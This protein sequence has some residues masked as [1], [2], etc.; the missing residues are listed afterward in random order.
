ML[1]IN[2]R[3]FVT[4]RLADKTGTNFIPTKG[5]AVITIMNDEV[6]EYKFLKPLVDEYTGFIHS[7]GGII[8]SDIE[9]MIR[10]GKLSF[11]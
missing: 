6:A 4:K 8:L 5:E 11:E 9:E 3:I 7:G 1:A 10:E 2:Q